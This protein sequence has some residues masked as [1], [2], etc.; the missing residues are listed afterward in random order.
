MKGVSYAFNRGDSAWRH[1]LLLLPGQAFRK[2]E[3]DSGILLPSRLSIPEIT[4]EEE[5]EKQA[6]VQTL[7][8]LAP[9]QMRRLSHINPI[10]APFYI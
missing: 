8:S 3:E 6:Q 4:K 1:L 10:Q 7:L 2:P 5:R 9:N